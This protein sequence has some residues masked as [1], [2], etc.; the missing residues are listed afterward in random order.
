[1]KKNSLLLIGQEVL[2]VITKTRSPQSGP[3]AMSA[4]RDWFRRGP[5]Q[6]AEAHAARSDG[7]WDPVAYEKELDQLDIATALSQSAANE[8]ARREENDVAFAKRLS[9]AGPC[10]PSRAEAAS[11]RLR[12]SDRCAHTALTCMALPSQSCLGALLL[13][14]CAL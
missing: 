13:E 3:T 5:V 10:T 8:A 9:L 11:L 2:F 1:M 6:P 14:S 12:N 4:L 7:A